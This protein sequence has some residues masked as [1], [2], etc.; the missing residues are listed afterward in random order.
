MVSEKHTMTVHRPIYPIRR[1][2]GQ[3]KEGVR[4]L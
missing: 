4:S 1:I 3:E 2:V